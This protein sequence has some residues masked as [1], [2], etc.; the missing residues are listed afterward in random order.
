MVAQPSHP[1]IRKSDA[2]VRSIAEFEVVEAATYERDDKGGVAGFDRGFASHSISKK[3]GWELSTPKT[4]K[5][6]HPN[7]FHLPIITPIWRTMVP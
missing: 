2:G 1:R 7:H 3:N 5:S 6:L 4:H